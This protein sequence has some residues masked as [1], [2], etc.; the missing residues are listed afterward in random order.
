[1][2]KLVL[3]AALA[4]RAAVGFALGPN[5]IMNSSFEHG[6]LV[7]WF[8]SS[9]ACQATSQWTHN[10]RSSAKGTGW[11]ALEQN[12]S[13]VPGT[14]YISS[15]W[16]AGSGNAGLRVRDSSKTHTIAYIGDVPLFRGFRQIAISWN[17][18][19]YNNVVVDM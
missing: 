13:V 14:N 5:L 17:S 7:S 3:T 4:F 1:M 19:T 12:V 18:S 9:N 15:V 6:D 11:A 8:S 16:A 2:K 10:G